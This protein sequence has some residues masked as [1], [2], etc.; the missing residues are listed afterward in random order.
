MV[1]GSRH[2]RGSDRERATDALALQG[3]ALAAWCLDDA[4]TVL[5][6][7]EA[8]TTLHIVGKQLCESLDLRSAATVRDVVA[9][10]GNVS[11]AATCRWCN[12]NSTDGVASLL[13]SGKARAAAEGLPMTFQVADAKKLLLAETSFDMVM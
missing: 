12:V 10:N 8:G 3:R 6:A 11:L 7:R 5:R 2:L 9:G 4:T 1:R 13:N